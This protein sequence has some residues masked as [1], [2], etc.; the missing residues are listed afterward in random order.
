VKATVAIT[1]TETFVSIRHHNVCMAPCH[2][3]SDRAPAALPNVRYRP[4]AELQADDLGID[5]RPFV[6]RDSTV[7]PSPTGD[8]GKEQFETDSGTGAFGT[9]IGA[10]ALATVPLWVPFRKGVVAG[11]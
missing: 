4:I 1:V 11:R 6:K 9:A 3:G 10:F 7:S 5:V 2:P 8:F